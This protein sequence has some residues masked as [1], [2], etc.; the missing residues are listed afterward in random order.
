MY[1]GTVLFLRCLP[2]AGLKVGRIRFRLLKKRDIGRGIKT[3]IKRE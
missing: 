3:G 2:N 1:S